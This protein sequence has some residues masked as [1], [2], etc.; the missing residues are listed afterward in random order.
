MSLPGSMAYL[1]A[2]LRKG[3]QKGPFI[4]PKGGRWA[5]AAHTI[6]YHSREGQ[7]HRQTSL[8]GA[9]DEGHHRTAPLRHVGVEEVHR[10]LKRSGHQL[11]RHATRE[12][13]G[14]SGVH[15]TQHSP[16]QVEVKHVESYHRD[17]TGGHRHEGSEDRSK[18]EAVE[19]GKHQQVVGRLKA[20][21]YHVHTDSAGRTLVGRRGDAPH[22][23]RPYKTR[24][25]D[26][27][28]GSLFGGEAPQE[29]QLGLF[30][31]QGPFIGPRGG[32]WADVEHTIPWHEDVGHVQI[33]KDAH[34]AVRA[35]AVQAAHRAVAAGADPET[36]R[37]MNAGA[38]GILFRDKTGK[39]FK[40]GRQHGKPS[41]LGRGVIKNKLKSEAEAGKILGDHGLGPRV[42]HY[43][44]AHDV[45]VRDHAE[46]QTGAW[47]DSGTL[48][49]THERV[50]KLLDKH[51]FTR[52]EFK[53]DSYIVEGG[54]HQLVDVGFVHPKGARLAAKLKE[55][56]ISESTPDQ[57]GVQMDIND[58]F[59]DGHLSRKEATGLLNRLGSEQKKHGLDILES[60]ANRLGKGLFRAMLVKAVKG[61]QKTAH[62]YIR[63]VP[64]PGGGWRYYYAESAAARSATEGEEV[65]LGDKKAKVHKVHEHGLTIEHEGKVKE[66]SHAE[67]TQMLHEHYGSRF[68]EWAEKRARQYAGAVLKHV[69]AELFGELKGDTDAERFADLKERLPA[70]HEKLMAAFSRAGVTAD[71]ARRAVSWTLTRKGWSEGARQTLLGSMLDRETAW[72]VRHYRRISN[73]AE[74]LAHA[75][76]A[77]GVDT[78]HVAAAIHLPR[79]VASM[80][81]VIN[82]ATAE[83]HHLRGILK[84]KLTPGPEKAEQKALALDLETSADALA[85]V[86]AAHMIGQLSALAKAYPG[87]RNDPAVQQLQVFLGGLQSVAPRAEPTTTGAET[88]LYVTGDYGKPTPMAAE[89]A[90]VDAGD[91]IASHDPVTFDQNPKHNVGNERAYHRDKAEQAKVRENAEDLKPELLINTN[92]DAVNGAPVVDE[93]G[94]VLGGNSRTMTMQLVYRQGGATA[95]GL[96]DYLSRSARQFGLKP[97]DV[98][99]MSQPILVRQVKPRD[100]EHKKLLVRQLNE[101]FTQAMDPRTMA[102][103]QARRV[104]ERTMAEIA[105]SLGPNQTLAAFLSSG[106]SAGF[107]ASL[108]R[109]G[110][111]TN[112]NQNA[113][114]SQGGHNQGKLNE[115]GRALVE[116]VLVGKMVG[117][118][119]LLSDL[120]QSL[121][122]SLARSVPHMIQAESSGKKYA[123]RDQLALALDAYNEIRHTLGGGAWPKKKAE[124]VR[125]LDQWKRLAESRERGG[126]LVQA[127]H[128]ALGDAMATS[129]LNTLV[130]FPGPQQMAAQFKK[131]AESA[132]GESGGSEEQMG[133]GVFEEKPADRVF[134][135][136]YERTEK[137]LGEAEAQEEEEGAAPAPTAP[138]EATPEPEP[139]PAPAPEAEAPGAGEAAPAEEPPAAAEK[140]AAA[141]VGWEGWKED[142]PDH[143]EAMNYHQEQDGPEHAAAAAAHKRA[144]KVRG[145]HR[146]SAWEASKK[147]LGSAEPPE[148]APAGL[149]EKRLGHLKQRAVDAGS[150]EAF[151]KSDLK[152]TGAKNTAHVV[153]EIVKNSR[154]R[155]NRAALTAALSKSGD[156][157]YLHSID[158]ESV[159][160]HT[161]GE[162]EASGKEDLTKPI[163]VDHEGKILDGRHR[164]M[165]ARKRGLAELPAYLPASLLYEKLG[166]APAA[167]ATDHAKLA[168]DH[169][170]TAEQLPETYTG[171]AWTSTKE[172]A[173]DAHAAAAKAHKKAHASPTPENK[174]A[175]EKASKQADEAVKRAEREEEEAAAQ[176]GGLF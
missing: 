96:K 40:V 144:M 121:V 145:Y 100:D 115:N 41:I 78:K 167:P 99:A 4:G 130:H 16:T 166:A 38:E 102:V 21:G 175:A 61:Q 137:D 92:P 85:K 30:K 112:Q 65:R 10:H 149:S 73:A 8:L 13:R 119:D 120:P 76:G 126:K 37:Y 131:Y 6:P 129:I 87:L 1:V 170:A 168:E 81:R 25:S 72:T 118:A 156:H 151:A 122:G 18:V 135:E 71:D 70:V 95:A 20:A 153:A 127:K 60:K 161:H 134:R 48:R 58:A 83:M 54:K 24:K 55:M 124:A 49:D 28:Q 79:T 154:G 66:V 33:E 29:E 93:S 12:E 44:H 34:E 155:V 5:D 139:A 159:D 90:L 136:A 107:I 160:A 109:S 62:K 7:E 88:T 138:T 2:Q 116:N 125:L 174:E 103:A 110:V 74:N 19:R 67:W 3:E 163:V 94:V 35:D 89:W 98:D 84:L 56:D 46:G 114:I 26:P 32:K 106:A 63:R 113:Y 91:L 143:K 82:R 176:Q 14:S 142:H 51:G 162:V 165:L 140:E 11:G 86:R 77:E 169:E 75:D 22:S 148:A 23:A 53:E 68:Y 47:S 171:H 59:E 45:I 27:R 64:K 104:D 147:A 97:G 42:H 17:H 150:R 111:I 105:T 101:S 69:P 123:V 132:A 146:K 9:S 57:F 152:G 15:A 39:V 157:H 36:V 50:T 108:R 128:P 52:P 158:L 31:A 172:R 43:S 141:P 173:Q 164:V 117:D 80:N 133:L